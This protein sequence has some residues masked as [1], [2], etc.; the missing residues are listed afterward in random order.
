MELAWS[1]NDETRT[2]GTVWIRLAQGHHGQAGS[3]SPTTSQTLE[4]SVVRSYIS[5]DQ[6]AL[7]VLASVIVVSR[8]AA[9]R[10]SGASLAIPTMAGLKPRV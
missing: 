8:V 10:Y 9:C 1:F 5:G 2:S 6:A 7:H 3:M 4:P